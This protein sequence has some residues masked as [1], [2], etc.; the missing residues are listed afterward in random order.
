MLIRSCFKGLFITK[1]Y[2]SDLLYSNFIKAKVQNPTQEQSSN[3]NNDQA[4]PHK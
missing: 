4:E 3:L 2:E 1:L